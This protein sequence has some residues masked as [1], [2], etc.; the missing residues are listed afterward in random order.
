VLDKAKGW[1]RF[2]FDHGQCDYDC[3]CLVQELMD[4]TV[5]MVGVVLRSEQWMSRSDT[6]DFKGKL[7]VWVESLVA[8]KG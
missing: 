1:P 4:R 5:P 3:T 8:K 6:T 7:R 2:Y